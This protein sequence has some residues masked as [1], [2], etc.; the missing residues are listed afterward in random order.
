MTG[1]AMTF[2]AIAGAFGVLAA[3]RWWQVERR[4]RAARL[5]AKAKQFTR[6]MAAR[7]RRYHAMLSR[8]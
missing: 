3:V 8:P 6:L 4:W 5:E 1:L 2:G 7:E